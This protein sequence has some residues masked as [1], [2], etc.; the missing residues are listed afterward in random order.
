M[1][2]RIITNRQWWAEL[3]VLVATLALA[4]LVIGWGVA[5]ALDDSDCIHICQSDVAS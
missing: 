2:G 5:I 3:I 1:T 4:V